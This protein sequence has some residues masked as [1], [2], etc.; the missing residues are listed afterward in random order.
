MVEKEL[1]ISKRLKAILPPLTDEQRK[2]LEADIVKDGR[3][4]DPIL[5]WWDGKQNVVIDGMHRLEIVR[6][7]GLTTYQTMPMPT[8][9]TTYE[10]VADWMF[11]RMEHQR[12]LTREQIGEW[13][14]RIKTSRGGDPGSKVTNGTLENAAKKVSQATG[15]SE[16]TVKRVGKRA[17]DI[18]KLIPQLQ[19]GISSG[20]VKVTDAQ[21][22]ALVGVPSE[23]QQKIA[24]DVRKEIL[25]TEAALAKHAKIKPKQKPKPPSPSPEPPAEP[26]KAK[27]EPAKKPDGDTTTCPTCNGSGRV[28]VTKTENGFASFWSAITGSNLPLKARLRKSRGQA[29]KAYKAAV[30]RL[31]GEGYSDPDGLLRA[32]VGLYAASGEA[33]KDEAKYCPLASTWLNGERYLEEPD[34]WVRDGKN[35]NAGM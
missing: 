33:N 34:Q 21:A 27:G 22:A 4:T 6:R 18:S 28:K 29:E 10:E 16:R 11:R 15:K 20:A 9:G 31:A 17:E 14:N 26:E 13:Y 5:Y 25:T 2:G 1:I 35:L 7:L 12:N 8:A 19:K 30:K 24:H 3:V 23:A 32:K